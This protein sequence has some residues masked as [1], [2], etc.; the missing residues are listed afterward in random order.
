ML[1][2]NLLKDPLSSLQ[3]MERYVNDGSPSGFTRKFTTSPTTTPFGDEERFRLNVLRVPAVW[4]QAQGH[5]PDWML[6]PSDEES[7]YLLVH[8]DMK[9]HVQLVHPQIHQLGESSFG[10]IPTASGRTVQCDVPTEH[11]YIK[12]HYDGILGRMNRCLTLANAT[13]AFEISQAIRSAV[14]SRRLPKQFAFLPE[15]DFR[16]VTIPGPEASHQWG[17][18]RRRYAPHARQGISTHALIPAFALFSRDKKNPRD[19]V[20][21]DQLLDAAGTAAESSFVETTLR[22]ILA[23]YFAL[24]TTLGLQPELNAQNLI[25]GLSTEAKIVAVILRDL[26]SVD[27]DVSLMEDLGI[28]CGFSPSA[29]KTLSRTQY[30][31]TIRHSLMFDFKFGEYLLAPLVESFCRFTGKGEDAITA[32]IKLLVEA[33]TADLPKDFFPKNL[34]YGHERTMIDRT[35]PARP[36]TK[37]PNPRFRS[38]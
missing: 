17:M 27:K 7:S 22:P 5:F 13:S 19:P 4:S 26:E 33:Y 12:L 9:G 23:S 2:E 3:H 30:D 10:A 8:P 28:H 14:D 32:A 1:L 31:Y 36:Y 24:L 34:W 25:F 11:D 29:F 15:E 35:S 18:I 16:V 37:Q 21:L 38:Q 6:P 20:L